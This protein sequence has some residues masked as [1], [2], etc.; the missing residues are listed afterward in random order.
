MEQ[1]TSAE[2]KTLLFFNKRETVLATLLDECKAEK[3][4]LKHCLK[5]LVL[6]RKRAKN[7]KATISAEDLQEN[8][9]RYD[10]FIRIARKLKRTP[11]A[12]VYSRACGEL[13]AL[14]EKIQA[15]ERE[16]NEQLSAVSVSESVEHLS[17]KIKSGIKQVGEFVD[18]A[19]GKLKKVVKGENSE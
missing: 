1:K 3:K 6:E 19:V 7:G 8:V 12:V 10:E 13:S 18:G 17:G 14:R 9:W 5:L 2:Y 16:I 11:N 15:E 4:M